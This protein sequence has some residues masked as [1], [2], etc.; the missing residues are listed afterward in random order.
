[1]LPSFPADLPTADSEEA[2][3]IHGWQEYWRV[4]EKFAADPVGFS[5]LTETQYVTTGDEATVIL[6]M[7]DGLREDRLRVDGGFVFRD[8]SLE[9]GPS[10]A[11]PRTALLT[12]CLD[13]S[14]LRVFDID[15]GEQIPNE[16]TL[17]ERTT[18][19]LLPDGVWRVAKITNEMSPC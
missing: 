16:G 10:T 5:D 17:K 4:Y 9:M 13:R 18:M 3:V 15:S 6:Q 1:M 2:A 12:Y 11:T 19:E 7:I 14:T 8:V